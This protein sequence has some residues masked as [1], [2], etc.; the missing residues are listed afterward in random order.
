MKG[1]LLKTG[2][3]DGRGVS[4]NPKA[5][6]EAVDAFRKANGVVS[7]GDIADGRDYSVEARILVK[8]RN[9]DGSIHSCDIQ[10]IDIVPS[11]LKEFE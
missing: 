5:L 2:V 1:V 6:K 9:E 4:Y 10:S 7:V 8:E 3:V 11:S